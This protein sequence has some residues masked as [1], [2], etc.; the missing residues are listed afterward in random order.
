MTDVSPAP[1]QADR[2]WW[3]QSRYCWA[4]ILVLSLLLWVPRLSGPID[5]RWDG[6]VY[7]LLGTSLA[8]GEGYRI[9]SEPGS[10]EAIQYPPLLPLFVALH[11]RVL[12]TTDPAVVAP[13]LRRS[14]AL[15]FVLFGLSL[16]ALARRFSTPALAFVAV[17]LC[18]CQLMTVFMS[19][20]LFAELPFALLSV[21][22]VLVA[23]SKR[24]T[25]W[26]R[27]PLLFALAASGF[28]LRT[29]GLAL[30]GAWVLDAVVRRHWR[31]VVVRAALALL[32]VVSWQAYVMKVRSSYDY[33]HP[34]YEY[35]RAPYQY[36]NVSYAENVA[37]V[38]PF[39]PELGHA[40]IGTIATRFASNVF[41]MLHAI[42]EAASTKE[43]F[44]AQILNRARRHLPLDNLI[45]LKL[46]VVPILIVCA[47]TF[48]GLAPLMRAGGGMI[49]LILLLSF[50]LA[51]TTPWPE[52]FS[53]YLMPVAPFI[54][55]C[56]IAGWRQLYAM[57]SRQGGAFQFGRVVL[58]ALLA[59]VFLLQLYALLKAF[60][61]RTDD[62]PEFDSGV[63]NARNAR[64]FYHD[65]TWTSWE[66][67][68][69]WIRVHAPS[70]AIV[71]TSAPHYLYLLTGRRAVLPPMERDAQRA[72]HLL[73][74]VP[75][76]YVVIDQLEFLD[77]TRRYAR[78][79][80]EIDPANWRV[81]YSAEGTSIYERNG[82]AK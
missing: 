4:A 82:A 48:L 77:V 42:G 80:V 54:C 11:E 53:R 51:A 65:K 7:Y 68:V 46:V 9:S 33:T 21:C 44:W 19:D 56:A 28:L 41:P 58:C 60:R 40:G 6:G 57:F 62:L 3:E 34:A 38:D 18:L 36:Y 66:K 8:S 75:V 5:L 55:I 2:W 64:L 32:P 31:T 50:S 20:L 69:S 39:R 22:F 23:M 1:A 81:V 52:Q 35:Q 45:P 72:E 12:G 73:A 47:I 13:W 70:D 30:L 16:F 37:L 25:A 24:L 14:Y 71:A 67:A 79:A 26:L 27:E 78:P 63:P 61:L 15:I 59:G 29:A 17:A 10:P 76:K 49:V 43:D 74:T